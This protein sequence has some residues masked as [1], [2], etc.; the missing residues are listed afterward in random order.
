M[1]LEVIWQISGNGLLKITRYTGLITMNEAA[2]TISL[3]SPWKSSSSFN[4]GNSDPA[5][6]ILNER[7]TRFVSEMER[8]RFGPA[9]IHSTP[10]NVRSSAR[11]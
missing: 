6:F 7:E 2:Y 4:T 9:A 8:D 5:S 1:V 3:I 10:R 11:K